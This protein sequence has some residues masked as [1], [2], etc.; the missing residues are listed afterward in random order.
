MNERSIKEVMLELLEFDLHGIE[1][2]VSGKRNGFGPSGE[3]QRRIADC[4]KTIRMVIRNAEFGLVDLDTATEVQRHRR[5][6][7]GTDQLSTGRYDI[8]YRKFRAG[9]VST[10]RRTAGLRAEVERLY[11]PEP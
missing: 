1:R 7:E 10:P 11:K 5:F 3:D 6:M 4:L 2:I 9:A 8:S